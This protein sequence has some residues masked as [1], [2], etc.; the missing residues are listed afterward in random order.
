MY[1]TSQNPIPVYNPIST[2]D[3]RPQSSRS[4][5]SVI[6]FP[7]CPSLNQLSR[8]PSVLRQKNVIVPGDRGR[9]NDSYGDE[10]YVELAVDVFRVQQRESIQSLKDFLTVLPNPQA[11]E[12]VLT[13]AIYQLAEI[14]SQACRWI[15]RHSTYLMPELDVK[16]YGMQWVCLKLQ[17]QGFVLNQDFQLGENLQLHLTKKAE[18]EL[19]HNISEGDRLILEEIFNIHDS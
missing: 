14:D 11:I 4:E 16:S 1:L 18:A 7:N 8:R 10:S 13:R 2:I 17:A 9:E 5:S 3:P 12:K 15:L 19:W 6:P